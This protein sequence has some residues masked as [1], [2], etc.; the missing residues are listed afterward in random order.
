MLINGKEKLIA[1]STLRKIEAALGVD[2]G[3]V[4]EEKCDG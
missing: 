1:Y 4:L 2:F 3:I